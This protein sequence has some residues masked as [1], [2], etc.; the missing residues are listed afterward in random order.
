MGKWRCLAQTA[1][2]AVPSLPPK[3]ATPAGPPEAMQGPLALVS[4]P[5]SGLCTEILVLLCLLA[6]AGVAAGECPAFPQ[7]SLS[8]RLR[9]MP[10]PPSP[11]RKF[12]LHRHRGNTHA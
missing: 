10:S 4:C 3:W 9:L 5:V 2:A 8:T 1:R 7:V 6:A 12:P 11:S